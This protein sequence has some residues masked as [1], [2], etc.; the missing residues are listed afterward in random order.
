MAL[1][2][3]AVVVIL[4]LPG[5]KLTGSKVQP[6]PSEY[7]EASAGFTMQQAWDATLELLLLAHADVFVGKFSSNLFRAAYSLR[8]AQCDCAPVFASLD[9]P[10][11]FDF[12]RRA[13]RNWEFPVANASDRTPSDATFEC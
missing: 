11:C 7:P 2:A 13:G 1:A 10:T 6:S 9:A 12:G 5:S 3:A 4:A 8:A